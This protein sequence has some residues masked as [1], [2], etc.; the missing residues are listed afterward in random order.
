MAPA[1]SAERG[2]V[3]HRLVPAVKA[4]T[5]VQRGYFLALMERAPHF[6]LWLVP[7]MNDG[8]VGHLAQQSLL[9]A[10]HSAAEAMS[11]QIRKQFEQPWRGIETR[12]QAPSSMGWRWR[13]CPVATEDLVPRPAAR[14]PAGR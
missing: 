1:E 7:K 6:R 2:S 11:R 14:T 5:A 9:T 8:E 10:S 3:L 12:W 4:A 13:G